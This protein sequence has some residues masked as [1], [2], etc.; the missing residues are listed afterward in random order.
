MLESTQVDSV[1]AVMFLMSSVQATQCLRS[2]IYCLPQNHASTFLD[3][4]SVLW[5]PHCWENC[6][7]QALCQ[8]LENT[9][10]QYDGVLNQIYFF[11]HSLRHY[12][13]M[14]RGFSLV[15]HLP[16]LALPI[17][18]QQVNYFLF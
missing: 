12:F 2:V 9:T 10:K 4:C 7:Q 8:V 13:V 17:K 3:W 16:P 18:S 11:P 5:M 14:T 1:A 15:S 6:S